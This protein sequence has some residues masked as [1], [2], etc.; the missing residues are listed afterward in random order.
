MISVV[1]PV[2]NVEKYI[3]NCLN[4]IISQSYTDY[5]IILVNDGS[6]D[7]SVNLINDF[8]KDKSANWTIINK[9]NGGLAS[10]RNAGILNAKGEVVAFIDSDDC[11]SS[12]YLEIVYNNLISGDY[13]FSF[14]N[15]EFVKTQIGPK[16]SNE[17]TVV[18]TKE[19]LLEVFLKRT[20]NFVVPSMMFRKDFLINNNLLFNE[21][22]KF[23]EDQPFIWNV[24]LH[25]NKSIYSYEK[26]YGYYVR[27][28]SIM[29]STSFDKLVN[30]LNE[31]KSY[32][33]EMFSNYPQYK[34]ITDM[35]L[36]RWELGSLFSASKLL[37][38]DKYQEYY[39]L[40]E[41]KTIL[42]KIKKIGEKK[43]LLLAFVSSLSPK[44]LYALCRKMNL[45]G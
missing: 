11:F 13:D 14:S 37:T 21:N 4:S 3:V 33:K 43:A 2:Y 38:Y 17:K 1:V 44:L 39:N 30:S 27:P 34:E 9:P 22:L 15:F 26:L 41:G 23:S 20:I 6:T 35:V 5:E 32:T 10:A 40:A 29:T 28:N 42:S 24:I 16:D 36:P 7:K 12:D 31:Y 8:F 18:Y 19:E 45:N 25:S